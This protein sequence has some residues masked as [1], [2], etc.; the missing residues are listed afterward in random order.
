MSPSFQVNNLPKFA[1]SAWL[2][3]LMHQQLNIKQGHKRRLDCLKTNKHPTCFINQLN[4]N[5]WPVQMA[6]TFSLNSYMTL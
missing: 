4:S 1:L 3:R 5:F 6:L 2:C